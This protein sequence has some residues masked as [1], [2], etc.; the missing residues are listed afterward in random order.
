MSI[1]RRLGILLLSIAILALC[2]LA[3]IDPDIGPDPLPT[4]PPTPVP[5]TPVSVQ[6]AVGVRFYDKVPTAFF[7]L[8]GKFF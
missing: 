7:H 8:L 3:C 4:A 5:A 1:S 6:V 2:T